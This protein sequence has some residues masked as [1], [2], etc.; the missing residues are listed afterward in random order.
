VRL[1]RIPALAAAVLL[2]GCAG[3]ADIAGAA[4]GGAATLVSANPAIGLGAGLAVRAG[5]TTAVN[6]VF[7]R[8]HRHAQDEIAAV[9]GRLAPGEG[10]PWRI[11]HTV[12]IGNARGEA[13]LIREIDTPLAACREAIFSVV[14]EE[15]AA[16][17]RQQWFVVTACRQGDAW[18][19]ASAEPATGRWGSLH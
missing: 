5:T 4:A 9:I 10:Q 17:R 16:T 7:R 11:D 18:K 13:H 1:G 3:G 6:W 8:R 19:W 15:S 14:E 2:A 12:P